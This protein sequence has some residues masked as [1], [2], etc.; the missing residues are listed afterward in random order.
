MQTSIS[1]VILDDQVHVVG[2]GIFR[3]ALIRLLHGL[4]VAK[5]NVAKKWL[6]NVRPRN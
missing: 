2:V 6:G 3:T 4:E 5:T 1:S